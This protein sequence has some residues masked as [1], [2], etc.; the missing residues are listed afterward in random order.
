M[1]STSRLAS[2]E[3]SSGSFWIWL[4]PKL[5]S[6]TECHVPIS[7]SKVKMRQ[8]LKKPNYLISHHSPIGKEVSAFSF[9]FSFWRW[10][11]LEKIP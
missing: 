9:M 10:L 6:T 4:V 5:S 8:M 2:M 7:E 1:C 11:A 3:I